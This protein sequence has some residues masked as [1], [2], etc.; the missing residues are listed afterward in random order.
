VSETDKAEISRIISLVAAGT[1]LIGRI[2]HVIKR[3]CLAKVLTDE[4]ALQ[5][6]LLGERRKKKRRQMGNP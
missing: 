5:G 1:L 3:A 6:P 2:A 4:T